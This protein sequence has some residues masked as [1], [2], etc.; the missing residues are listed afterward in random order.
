MIAK[1]ELLSLRAKW[2]I[3]IPII[4]KDYV[5]GWLLAAIASEPALAALGLKCAYVDI[6]VPNFKTL[7]AS[8]YRGEA[9]TE[10]ENML[11]H[12]LPAPL[13]PFEQ[14]WNT[15]YE[16]FEWLNSKHLNSESLAPIA[17]D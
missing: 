1:R 14:F 6:R 4:E 9:K 17:K 3:D 8:P 2:G 12:Q 10:W 11:A 5:L 16:I 15:L 7:T 13:A